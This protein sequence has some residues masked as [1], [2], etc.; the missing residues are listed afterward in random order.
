LRNFSSKRMYGTKKAPH[1][2]DGKKTM[3]G[4]TK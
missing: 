2:Q 3:K 1:N 4:E